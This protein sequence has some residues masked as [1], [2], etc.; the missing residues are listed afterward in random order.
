MTLHPTMTAY[1]AAV[2][3]PWFVLEDAINTALAAAVSARRD[4][5]TR[6]RMGD[7]QGYRKRVQDAAWYRQRAKLWRL[8]AANDEKDNTQ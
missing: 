1:E 5:W 3:Q 2:S 4:A 7:E 6:R 8:E